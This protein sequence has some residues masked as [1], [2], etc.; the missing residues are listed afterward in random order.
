MTVRNRM[1][2]LGALACALALGAGC[3]G[4]KSAGKPSAP[5]PTLGQKLDAMA[6][7]AQLDYLRALEKEKPNDATIAFHVG[8]A[9]Y[10]I[11]SSLPEEESSR[12]TAYYDSAV[13]AYQRAVDLDSTY[14]K[15]YVNMGLAYD[16][17][18]RRADARRVLKKAIEVNPK[19]VL[20]YC[21]LGLVEQS[22]GNYGEAVKLY[23][24]ALKLD[25]N[26]AQAH[27]NLGLAF[28]ET[29]VFK[30]AMVEWEK[31]IALDP[32]GE[33]GKTASENV[34]IIRQYLETKP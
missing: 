28:A 1:V 30:E 31:V 25:P 2:S 22:Y 3:G 26:S 34:R 27:Y 20:A 23:Q 5:A 18:Q 33:L 11:G 16:A 29:K 9:Y 19:D 17:G 10:A 32:D 24:E 15:A 4:S 13:T 21:H 8:N 14:S 7:E 12:S 6:P